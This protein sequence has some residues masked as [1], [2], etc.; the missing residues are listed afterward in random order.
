MD[1][2]SRAPLIAVALIVLGTVL[3]SPV[4]GLVE[5]DESDATGNIGTGTATVSTVSLPD[6]A[7][8]QRGRYGSETYYLQVAAGSVTFDRITGKPVLSYELNVDAL[9]YSR[10]TTYF[11]QPGTD[12]WIELTIEKDNLEPDSLDEDAYDAELRLV[13]RGD[14]ESRVLRQKNVTVQVRE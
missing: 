8:F 6:E 10:Q 5:F 11:L 14:G 2:S 3:A 12:E 9:G 13:L 1:R 4:V 7:T